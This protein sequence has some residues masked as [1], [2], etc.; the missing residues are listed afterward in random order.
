MS[1]MPLTLALV[2]S[3]RCCLL[4]ACLVLAGGR[5]A[6][7]D[8]PSAEQWAGVAQAITAQDPGA[9]AK[10]LAIT[11][12]FPTWSEGFRTLAQ[13]QL[14]GRNYDAAVASARTALKLDA[15]DSSAAACAV[16]ALGLLGHLDDACAIADR[17]G[18][19]KD[20]KGL[21]NYQT[22]SAALAAKD[23]AKAARYLAVAMAQ[24]NDAPAEFTYLDARIAE[25]GG[26]LK[27]AAISL[28]RAT[29]AS[30]R[31]WD[32]WYELGA[33][34]AQ[35]SLTAGSPG[36]AIELL[37]QS[38]ASFNKA[39]TAQEK[40]F[41]CWQGLGSTQLRLSQALLGDNPSDGKAKAHEAAT[42]LRN[43]LALKEDQRDA[44]LGLG[45]ALL[46]TEDWADAIPHLERARALGVQDRALAFNL[47]L[48][49]QKAGRTADFEQ[50]A[51]SLKAISPGEKITTGMG[52]YHAG[53]MAMA[54]NLLSSAVGDLDHERDRER[55][56]AVE[57]F[58]GH[59]HLALVEQA[60]KRANAPGATDE[61]KSA[62]GAEVAQHL[63]AA[64]D[65]YRAGGDLG[66]FPSR[67]HFLAL[68]TQRTSDAGYAAGWQY[69]AWTGY[70]APPGW[71][72]VIGNYGGAI[73]GGAGL[74]G[75]WERH[76]VHVV[77]W[78]VLA[79]IP[80]L[81]VLLSFVRGSPPPVME[82]AEPK[83][84]ATN[85]PAPPAAP[86]PRAATPPAGKN[87][88]PHPGAPPSKS[89][90]QQP[91]QAP[92]QAPAAKNRTTQKPNKAVTEAAY[93]TKEGIDPAVTS[94]HMPSRSKETEA[95]EDGALERRPPK[96]D[97]P[98]RRPPPPSAPPSRR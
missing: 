67:H 51:R 54:A 44:Q 25:A 2:P 17:F 58:I 20:A 91:P 8:R 95:A 31:F 74:G 45:Q 34:Q 73:T 23:R 43:S 42:S 37:T 26:D 60:Q 56:G 55:L 35:L 75:M 27:R 64:R 81:L 71:A 77:V 48:A 33:V 69:L 4:L 97:P 10:V 15:G 24:T 11:A 50:A 72:A 28:G 62:A 39:A 32:A 21:V 63:D 89:R 3:G 68:E 90:I 83:R 78:G 13:M 36:E 40:D 41:Q 6:G 92:A 7:A 12:A 84:R 52:L 22:A 30:P 70:V 86:Q 82:A 94:V 1:R 29:A 9:E 53:Q 14:R 98:P 93:R 87:R 19:A 85:P 49:Y 47:M 59:A 46:L 38:E 76:P 96:S 65:A 18:G 57:R 80:A 61:Q 66:D 88:T 79:F 16:Q 5:C